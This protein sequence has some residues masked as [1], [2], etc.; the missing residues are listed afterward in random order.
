MLVVLMNEQIIS[1]QTV[2]QSCLMADTQG[3]PR[4]RRGKLL[5]GRA[6]TLMAD[7]VSDRPNQYE[8]QMGFRIADIN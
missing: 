1:P 7:E 8:C 5:C 6:L 4:W 3:K 2:C